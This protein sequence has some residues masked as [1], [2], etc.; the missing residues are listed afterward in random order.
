MEQSLS[1]QI[2]RETFITVIILQ[3]DTVQWSRKYIRY[4]CAYM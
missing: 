3:I 4:F 1:L 2:W